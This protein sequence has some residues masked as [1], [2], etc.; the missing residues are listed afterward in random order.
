M[1]LFG[2]W[3]EPLVRSSTAVQGHHD[4]SNSRKGKRL[5]RWQLTVPEVESIVIMAGHTMCRRHGAGERT[6][7]LAG[8]RKWSE[9]VAGILSIYETS[10]STSTVT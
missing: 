1:T 5:M 4:D 8:N 10:K 2:R 9:T 3:K 6:E 7:S